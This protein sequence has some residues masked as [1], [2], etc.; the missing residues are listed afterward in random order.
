MNYG[1]MQPVAGRA[2]DRAM[3]EVRYEFAD[4]LPGLLEHLGISVLISTYQAGKLAVIGGARGD[5]DLTFHN[6]D[7]PMGLAVDPGLDRLAVATRDAILV[8]WNEVE[9]ARRLPERAGC[10]FLT[11]KAHVTGDIQAHQI[12]WAG[13]ELWLVNTRFSCLCTL[14]ERHSFVP[15]WQPGFIDA[16]VAEDRCHL[17]GLAIAGGQPRYVTA[18]ARTNVAEG[19]RPVKHHAGVLLDVKTGDAVAENLAMPHS[20]VVHDGAILLLDSGRGSLVRVTPAGES[21]ALARFPGY[22]RGLAVYHDLALVGLS[23]IRETSTF[24]NLPILDRH[25]ELKC[26]FVI[27][28]LRRGT[29]VSQLEFKSG[30]DEIF[31]VATVAHPGRTILRGPHPAQDGHDTMWVV[32][33]AGG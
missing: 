15:R 13:D 9:I 24:D 12:G 23:K 3:R 22:T 6:Y 25:Q 11:R 27:M 17:S 29:L 31:D 32:P 1:E 20:P 2:T 5:L 30:I 19:W 7:R 33:A 4:N 14:D 18:L 21:Q 28:D 10:C 16:L 8:A 26:G